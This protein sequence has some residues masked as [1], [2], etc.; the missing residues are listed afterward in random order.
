MASDQRMT[1][2]TTS[3]A[4]GAVEHG[5][6]PVGE[7]VH[8]VTELIP[9]LIKQEM[10]LAKAELGEKGKK[11]GIGA[12]LFGGSG[13]IAF[14]GLGAL[15]TAAILGLAEAVP[16]WLSA[17]IVAVVLFVIAGV[18]AL[19]GKKEVSQA[20]PPVPEHAISGVKEDVE[21]VKESVHR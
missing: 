11:A 13:A 2:A 16:G 17:L 9:K 1:P 7:L 20:T 5:D 3:P 18:L 6:R 12:G 15:I 14:Y 10:N 21:T 8:E 4:T 19:V